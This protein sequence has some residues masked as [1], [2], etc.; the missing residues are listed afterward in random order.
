MSNN[1]LVPELI[2]SDL[3]KS[4][5]FY[6]DVLGFKVE[7]ERQEDRFVYLSFSGS[8]LMLEEDCSESSPWIIEPLDYPRGRGL[9]LSIECENAE[10]LAIRLFESDYPLQKELED[11]QTSTSATIKQLDEEL[12]DKLCHTNEVQ[13]TLDERIED[14]KES[15]NALEEQFKQRT[16]T[17]A[18]CGIGLDCGQH[19][20]DLFMHQYRAWKHLGL[21][22][23][24]YLICER[25]RNCALPHK[26]A[27]KAL[28]R[29][30][31][32]VDRACLQRP[33]LPI[34][35]SN[36]CFLPVV[37]MTA[38]D[39]FHRVYARLGKPC[40]KMVEIVAVCSDRQ[41]AEV[42]RLQMA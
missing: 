38:S 5:R 22:D 19:P 29:F 25:G 34:Q 21:L 32:L 37:Q 23:V 7:Y 24:V 9:N 4:L 11:C 35:S 13:R 1:P 18:G 26:V 12:V 15:C 30:N 39:L 40:G 2:V 14:A 6:R 36:E 31:L 33:P 27:K 28:H 41:F 42:Q 8:E 3:R 10:D 16:V 20:S 17:K